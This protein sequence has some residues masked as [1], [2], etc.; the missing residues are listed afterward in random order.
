MDTDLPTNPLHVAGDRPITTWSK[1]AAITMAWAGATDATSGV[2]GYS[3][4]WAT[5]FTLPDQVEDTRELSLHTNIP[6]DGQSWYFMVRAVDGA[7]NWSNGAAWAGP[8][9]LDATP[10]TNPYLFSSNPPVDTWSNLNRIQLQWVGAAD[11]GGSGVHGY[12]VVMKHRS[13][14]GTA[15]G[16]KRPRAVQQQCALSSRG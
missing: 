11:A 10:P 14:P 6:G 4:L 3:T 8:F 2:H 9:W 15:G 16:G 1:A 7:G 13:G 5:S 12:N